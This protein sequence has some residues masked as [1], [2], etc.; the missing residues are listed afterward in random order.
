[1]LERV[2]E[3]LTVGEIAG[4]GLLVSAVVIVVR[5]VWQFLPVVAGEDGAPAPVRSAPATAGANGC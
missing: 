1:M 2:G 4:Y 3:Q 5:I